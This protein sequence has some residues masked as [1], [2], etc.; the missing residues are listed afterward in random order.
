MSS[1]KQKN[2]EP[3]VVGMNMPQST[4]DQDNESWFGEN[5]ST[6]NINNTDNPY[7]ANPIKVKLSDFTDAKLY[8]ETDGE[9]ESA[10]GFRVQHRKAKKEYGKWIR[11]QRRTEGWDN[12]RVNKDNIPSYSE[13]PNP[14]RIIPPEVRARMAAVY[15][16]SQAKEAEKAVAMQ[17]G[18]TTTAGS[19]RNRQG[20]LIAT[21]NSRAKSI[22]DDEFEAKMYTF[23][24]GQR[25]AQRR[26]EL[27]LTQEQ[28]AFK[29][30][31]DSKTIS[32][33]ERGSLIAYNP[34]DILT[35]SLARELGWNGI[36]Y[37]K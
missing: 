16:E 31:V 30:G 36:K 13:D 28:L 7:C 33:I 5:I 9:A 10:D 19:G 34:A 18:L 14:I 24:M 35:R 32:N 15:A 1:N 6:V 12:F 8:S 21:S 23:K 29:V 17:A 4:H 25:I 11:N 3:Y 22:Y 20:R 27:N 2:T 26:V 37:E